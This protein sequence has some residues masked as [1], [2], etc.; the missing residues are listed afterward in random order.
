MGRAGG[1]PSVWDRRIELLS[2]ALIA[3]TAVIAAWSAFQSAKWGGVMSI[4]FSEA[5]AS[6]TESTRESNVANR[7]VVVDVALF[8]SFADAVASD[9]EELA[10]FYLERFP[11]RLA[12]AAEA[13]LATDPLESPDAPASPFDM[14]EYVLEA[15]SNAEELEQ[16]AE[17]RSTAAREAN[18]RSDNYTVTS[19]FFATVLLLAALSV[20]VDDRVLQRSLLG[21]AAIVFVCTAVVIATFPVEV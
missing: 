21:A 12:V 6:R 3:L 5:A 15:E 13:W 4:R 7:Q 9:D 20:K 8:T 17:E 10:D 16:R 11:E 14:P 1:D 18:Q 19:I 2:V